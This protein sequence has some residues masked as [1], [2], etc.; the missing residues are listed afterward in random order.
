MNGY[1]NC[2]IGNE[3][4]VIVCLD[5]VICVKNC[6]VDGVDYSGIYGIIIFFFGVLRFQFVKKNDNG[7]NVGFRVYFMVSLDKYKLFN[8]FN[9][10]F[11]FDVDVFKF[12]CGLNGVVYF[13]EMFEDGGFKF[14]SGNKVGVKYGIG[15]CDF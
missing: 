5:G 12:L 4:N 11:I 14:F 1:I 10:E 15:Y 13:S 7:Q 8:F 6:V 2:Y 3:W 9:K